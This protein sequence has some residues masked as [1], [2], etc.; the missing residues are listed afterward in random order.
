ENGLPRFSDVSKDAGIQSEGW[1]L[2]IMVNDINHDG[3]PDV[4]IAND[5]TSNDHLY[6][7]SQ[8]NTFTNGIA[9]MLKRQEQNGMGVDIADINNDG[10]NDIVALDMLPDDNLRQKTMFSNIGY[11]R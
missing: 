11:D 8:N 3:Y 6:L 10:L 7:N 1:G 4:Y 5:F 2:G 9:S